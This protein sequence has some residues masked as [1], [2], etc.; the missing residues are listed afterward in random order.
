MSTWKK[1]VL[2]ALLLATWSFPAQA[3]VDRVIA[4]AEG[5]T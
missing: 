2:A 5:I 1:P 3:Q 4:E